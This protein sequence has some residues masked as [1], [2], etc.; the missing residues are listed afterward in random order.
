MSTTYITAPRTTLEEFFAIAD[1][2]GWARI[3]IDNDHRL[4]D[5]DGN[6]PVIWTP[7]NGNRVTWTCYGR[8]DGYE[9]AE[10]TGSIDEYNDDF[11]RFARLN[12]RSAI[13]KERLR[14]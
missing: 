8:T 9:L 1:E 14:S 13:R 7:R 10:A 12:G 11:E 5:E 4:V 3:V 2:A 6:M